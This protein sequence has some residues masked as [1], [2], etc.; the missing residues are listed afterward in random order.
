VDVHGIVVNVTASQLQEATVAQM[1]IGG[2]LV[3]SVFGFSSCVSL[4]QGKAEHISVNS[5]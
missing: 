5:T 3:L 1:L 4:A 2:A